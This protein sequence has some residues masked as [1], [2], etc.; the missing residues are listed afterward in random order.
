MRRLQ[1][2]LGG[3]LTEE[4]QLLVSLQ[5]FLSGKGEVKPAGTA[6]IELHGPAKDLDV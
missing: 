1:P 3:S 4:V 5:G 2:A 6:Q